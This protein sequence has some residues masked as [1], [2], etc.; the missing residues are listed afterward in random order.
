MRFTVRTGLGN[1][2]KFLNG[3]NHALFSDYIDDGK[4]TLILTRIGKINN[5]SFK[6]FLTLLE[7]KQS[8]PTRKKDVGNPKSNLVACL[9][10]FS[11]LSATRSQQSVTHTI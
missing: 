5:C 1:R 4:K 10:L 11:L 2:L 8:F 6:L 7:R 3:H 9:R